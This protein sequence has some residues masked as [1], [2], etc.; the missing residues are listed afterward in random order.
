MNF[1]D[2][3]SAAPALGLKMSLA[4]KLRFLALLI[5]MPNSPLSI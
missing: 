3:S 5:S 2:A 4:C 1:L